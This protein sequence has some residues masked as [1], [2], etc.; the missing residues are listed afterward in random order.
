MLLDNFGKVAERLGT[1]KPIDF[2]FV[3]LIELM[4]SLQFF[5][6]LNLQLFL[7]KDLRWFFNIR[8]RVMEPSC[9]LVGIILLSIFR[10][11]MLLEFLIGIVWMPAKRGSLFEKL[12]DVDHSCL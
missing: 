4:I 8:V 2:D 9:L 12:E 11:D 5:L 6:A 7:V 3:L 1:I 10:N